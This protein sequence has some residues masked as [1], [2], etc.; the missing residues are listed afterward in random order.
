MME[1]VERVWSWLHDTAAV[2]AAVAAFMG[3]M[4]GFAALLTAIW[5]A[6]RLYNEVMVA[7][8]RRR[9]RRQP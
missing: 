1:D 9:K 2:S 6:V 7:V 8:D 4:P 3:W 5:C